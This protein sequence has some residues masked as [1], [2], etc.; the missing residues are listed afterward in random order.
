MAP[1]DITS[2]R[3][4]LAA[5]RR[6]DLE[7]AEEQQARRRDA[8]ERVRG[9][10]VRIGGIG[11]PV[12]MLDRAAEELGASSAFDRV[13]IS[14]LSDDTLTPVALWEA[15]AGPDD[16]SAPGALDGLATRLAYPLIEAEVVQRRL[17]QIVDVAAVAGR[18]PAALRERFGWS[19]YV[20]AAMTLH[21]KAIGLVHVDATASGRRLDALDRDVA[22]LYAVGLARCFELAVLRDTLGHHRD[23]QWTA[24]QWMSERLER[25]EAPGSGGDEAF[26]EL[27]ADPLTGREREVV[28]LLCRG[29]TNGAIARSLTISE[30]T[31]KYHVGNVLRKLGATSRADAVARYLRSDD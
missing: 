7:L 31:A 22:T 21:D 18:S 4:A 3:A 14:R 28:E 10:V 11:S 17:T 26:R 19:S 8:L 29:M 30:G 20:V 23:E 15:G 24:V 1:V 2:A 5:L 13:L 27:R 12:G 9:A 6:L 25:A 16:A